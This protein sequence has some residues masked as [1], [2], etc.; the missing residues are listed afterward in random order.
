MLA[1][2]A[3]GFADPV[4]EA[5]DVFRAVM[6]ALARPGKVL[7]LDTNL[8]PPAPL[9]P[10]LAAIAL[11]LC[12]HE[13]PLWLDPALAA[14]PAVADYLRFHTGAP[15]IADPGAAAFA[16]VS[17]VPRLPALSHFAQGSDEYPDRST[18]IVAAVDRIGEGKRLALEGPGIDGRMVLAVEPLPVNLA[19]QLQENRARFPRG[20]DLLFAAPGKVAALPRSTEV[21]EI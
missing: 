7:A 4:L 6:M 3:P 14:V 15:L 2:A 10:E 17:D 1:L 21:R 20:V 11:A 13:T 8:T 9:T 16:L 12:D 19:A 18:T 5:Q